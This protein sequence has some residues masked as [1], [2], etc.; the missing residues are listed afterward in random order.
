MFHYADGKIDEGFYKNG[1]LDGFGKLNF[2]N[3]DIYDGMMKN[4]L[5]EGYGIFY[6]KTSNKW[7]YGLFEENRCSK[8]LE[9]GIN[10]PSDI[11]GEFIF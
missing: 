4:G 7:V 5:F 10:K 8:V 11:I 2:Y 9:S 3:G 6:K 1:L